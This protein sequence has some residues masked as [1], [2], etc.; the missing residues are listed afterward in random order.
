MLPEA[1]K[2][3]P[4]ASRFNL[5]GLPPGRFGPHFCGCRGECEGTGSR[6]PCPYAIFLHLSYNFLDKNSQFVDMLLAYEEGGYHVPPQ[7]DRIPPQVAPAHTAPWVPFL[8][9]AI[10]GS[11]YFGCMAFLAI[12]LPKYETVTRLLTY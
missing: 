10:P 4:G 1:T 3:L 5:Q 8:V 12:S 7:T 6:R 9:T 2:L 11:G